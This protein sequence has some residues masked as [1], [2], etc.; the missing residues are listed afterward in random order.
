MQLNYFVFEMQ[1]RKRMKEIID[2]LFAFQLESKQSIE[3]FKINS[4]EFSKRLQFIE[5]VFEEGQG[6]NVVFDKVMEQCRN[7]DIER[8]KFHA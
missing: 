6:K 8:L 5:G 7:G 4:T 2:P 1:V 3:E